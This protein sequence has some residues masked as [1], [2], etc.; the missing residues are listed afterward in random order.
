MSKTLNER[1]ESAVEVAR[2]FTTLRLRPSTQHGPILAGPSKIIEPQ[3]RRS[4]LIGLLTALA[5]LLGF[6]WMYGA[7]IVLVVTNQGELTIEVDDPDV[8]VTVR[9]NDAEVHQKSTQRRFRVRPVHGEV[10][11]HDPETGAV[12]LTKRFELKRAGQHVAVTVTVRELSASAPSPAV[13][14]TAP[15]EQVSAEPPPV[16]AESAMPEMS[17]SATAHDGAERTP[18]DV[19]PGGLDFVDNY[20]RLQV[21]TTLPANTPITVELDVTC[22]DLHPVEEIYYLF[23]F[24]L[25][26]VQVQ[27]NRVVYIDGPWPDYRALARCDDI[28]HP[29]RRLLIAATKSDEEA[30][31]FI[32]GRKEVYSPAR[33][34]ESSTNA[35]TL[36]LGRGFGAGTNRAFDGLIH[37]ARV[38]RG[39]RWTE[40]YI[41]EAEWQP[42]ESTL[43]LY[44]FRTVDPG[45]E[46]QDLSGNTHHGQLV[47]ARWVPPR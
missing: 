40:H 30:A 32:N 43:A 45:T 46:A 29:G 18:L 38:F 5:I 41:P 11:F 17:P 35:E 7:A 31:L 15:S 1:P 6:G 33:R 2:E 8:E 42:D 26:K 4:R 21:L 10:E 39:V 44:D 22:H 9:Q 28:I 37:R 23:N 19:T 14:A 13:P 20:G 16:A 24:G 27:A 36:Y 3:P 12:A 34:P 47:K 25:A